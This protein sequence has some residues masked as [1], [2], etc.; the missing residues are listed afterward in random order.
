MKNTKST[1]IIRYLNI[2]LWMQA[3]IILSCLTIAVPL[4]TWAQNVEPSEQ[5]T[6]LLMRGTSTVFYYN[7]PSVNSAGE[8]IVLSSAL[9]AW[10]PTDRRD[11]DSI[12]SV[13]IYS[14]ATI[15]ADE[16]RPTSTGFSKEQM[17]LQS[18]P[19]R[20]Y[21]YEGDP[22]FDYI[23]HCII[24]APDYEGYGVTKDLPHPYLSQRL[25]ARQVLDAVNY[26]LELYRKQ[27]EQDTPDELLLPLKNDWRMFAIGYSQGGAVTLAFQRLIEEEG[28]SEQL[29]FY[30]SLC[31]DGPYDL[32]ETL[33]YYFEDDGTSYGV[34]T[35]HRKN[36][37]TYPVVV[38]LI[39]KGMCSTHP[40]MA[41]Y[42]IED[43]LSQ[44]LIDT[45]VLSWIDSKEY[46]TSEMSKMWYDQLMSGLTAS[47]RYY[48]PEQMAELFSSPQEDKVAGHLEKMFTPATFAYLS[49]ADSMSVVP[50]N[51]TTAQQALHLALADNSVATGWVPQHRIQFYHSHAD[52]VVPYGN[53]L[54][55]RDAHSDTENTIYRIDD[56]FYDSDHVT[57]AVIFFMNLC[58]SSTYAPDFQWICEGATPTG[59]D[60][61][62]FAD[63]QR[64]MSG[65][66]NWYTL[67][68]RRLSSR[69]T[70]NG[71]YIH[72]QKKVVIR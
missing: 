52:M 33:R 58:P 67:D 44:Q 23:G 45:G 71:V 46:T 2:P 55:F 42:S 1:T 41:K 64:R 21:V 22:A 35:N 5:L 25:T 68:G 65:D 72:N 40:A 57:A 56:P 19:K 39:I 7:Y 70:M 34:K 48:S 30:G 38:P 49:N 9:I 36:M 13:H 24:I 6:Q 3:V 20:H 27:T 4:K 59:I 63:T 43:Y 26:G 31:G 15:G 66:N 53:Y 54:A 16:E 28:L 18:M 50:T 32:I 60:T 14:H 12:E 47:G 61:K 37:S 62:H 51:L 69:P 8:R 10:T 29:H 11:T 17:V